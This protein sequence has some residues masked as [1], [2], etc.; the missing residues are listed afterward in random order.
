MFSF[1]L[2]LSHTHRHTDTHTHTDKYEADTLQG[3]VGLLGTRTFCVPHFFDYRKQ[4]SFTLH[5]LP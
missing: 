3:P 2:T 5:D 4:P 1:T